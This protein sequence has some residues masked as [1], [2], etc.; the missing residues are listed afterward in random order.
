MSRQL[1]SVVESAY[2]LGADRSTWLARLGESMREAAGVERAMALEV[3]L[4][5]GRVMVG[6]TWEPDLVGMPLTLHELHG[7]MPLELAR[8]L[9]GRGFMASLVSTQMAEAGVPAEGSIITSMLAHIGGTD[10]FGVPGVDPDGRGVVIAAVTGAADRI[11]PGDVPAWCQVAAHVAAGYRLR[12]ALGP[13][14]PLEQ[15]EAVLGVDGA[16]EHASGDEAADARARLREAVQRMDRARLRGTDAH[17]ALSLWEGLVDGRWS[18][19]DHF[20][21]D[22]RRHYV[23]LRNPPIARSIRGLT[24]RERMAVEL[25]AAGSSHKV[26]AYALGVDPST[27]AHL[28]GRA[29]TKLGLPSRTALIEL[30]AHLGRAPT[31]DPP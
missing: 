27:F 9:Y 10:V 29:L 22:G 19:V 1:L 21:S 25:A 14:S 2:D 8:S 11:P 20:D 31:D 4:R 16:L 3:D 28:L 30:A 6:E 12:G 23:A 17:E 18:L 15:A 13:G 24:E 5:P 7:H 26:G